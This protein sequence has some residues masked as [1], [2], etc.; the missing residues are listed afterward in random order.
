MITPTID[1][2][3]VDPSTSEAWVV[4]AS[5]DQAKLVRYH[6][7]T[8]RRCL[9]EEVDHTQ[10]PMPH[11]GY[12]PTRHV[13]G[14]LDRRYAARCKLLEEERRRISHL[15]VDWLKAA[16]KQ[17]KL[18][19]ITV[20]A[21]E[22]MIRLLEPLVEDLQLARVDLCPGDLTYQTDDKLQRHPTIMGR[23]QQPND[24]APPAIPLD[25]PLVDRTAGQYFT[26]PFLRNSSA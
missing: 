6:S 7:P 1:S 13:P 10:S 25:G 12:T 24:T 3:T 5:Y 22:R 8:R 11:T 20:F 26:D 18:S 15:L 21:P 2:L 17:R 9:S 14:S 16:V 19:H 4:L 23:L